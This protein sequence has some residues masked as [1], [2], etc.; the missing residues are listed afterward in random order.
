MSYTNRNRGVRR[1]LCARIFI[2]AIACLIAAAEPAS[3]APVIA[4]AADQFV[5][6]V[7]V[8]IG[9]GDIFGAIV[10]AK[11]VDPGGKVVGVAYGRH[12]AERCAAECGVHFG[13]LS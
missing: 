11:H 4:N 10:V 12:D 6:S 13:D 3:A 5:E 1:A 8:N 2:A 9:H 7:G